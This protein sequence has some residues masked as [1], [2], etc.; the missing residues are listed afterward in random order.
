[1]QEVW[2]L[3]KIAGAYPNYKTELASYARGLGRL[4]Y[5]NSCKF[6]TAWTPSLEATPY[7]AWTCTV[8]LNGTLLGIGLDDQ[9]NYAEA[10]ASFAALETLRQRDAVAVRDAATPKRSSN[11]QSR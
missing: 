3:Q 2:D 6:G 11:R 1:M 10:A 5:H 9:R 4:R 8:M 7:K